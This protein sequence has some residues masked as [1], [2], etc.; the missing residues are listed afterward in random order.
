MPTILCFKH[1][2]ESLQ[3]LLTIMLFRG[4]EEAT[5]ILGVKYAT[6]THLYGEK[7]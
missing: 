6:R 5:K 3:F 7:L 1:Y 4:A 2:S